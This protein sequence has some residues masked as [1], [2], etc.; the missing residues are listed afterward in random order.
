M[1]ELLDTKQAA[2]YL[3]LA[4]I[5]LAQWRQMDTGPPYVKLGRAVRYDVADLAHWIERQK[6]KP[7]LDRPPEMPTRGRQRRSA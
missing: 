5:T 3:G 7:K 2:A 1:S 6:V 4:Q